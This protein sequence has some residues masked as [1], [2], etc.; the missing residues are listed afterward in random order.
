M[1]LPSNPLLEQTE[2]KFR[3]KRVCLKEKQIIDTTACHA[4]LRA[5]MFNGR[6]SVQTV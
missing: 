3:R 4:W 1:R 5:E 2:Q 6:Q